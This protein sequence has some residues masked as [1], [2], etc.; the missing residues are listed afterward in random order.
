[1]IHIG[2]RW[3]KSAVATLKE[4]LAHS[5]RR[6]AGLVVLVLFASGK[7]MQSG[8]DWVRESQ[9]LAR[10]MEAPLVVNEDVRGGWSKALRIETREG[11]EQQVEWR[12]VS[13]T[14]GI[15][16][17]HSGEL[18]PA[19][20]AG[21]LDDFLFKS[22]APGMPTRGL[23]LG[24]RLS[25][26]AFSSDISGRFADIEPSCPPPPFGR[27]GYDSKITFVTR[28][29]VASENAIRKLT[30]ESQRDESGRHAAVVFEGAKPEEIEELKASLPE[31]ITAVADPD[32]TISRRF[33][34]RSWPMSVTLNEAGQIS[35]F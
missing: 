26:A 5:R 29:S 4:G 24:T 21:A 33:G 2:S 31:G 9:E 28:G 15:T 8:S 23:P 34:V 11:D 3:D 18:D 16:W 12:L 27:L 20:L 22:A 32:G 17:A 1:V 25:P 6:D 13:P 7:L 19:G 14:G 10:V 35:G 30:G